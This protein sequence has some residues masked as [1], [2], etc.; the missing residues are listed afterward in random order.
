MEPQQAAIEG[1]RSGLLWI[2]AWVYNVKY[3]NVADE[4]VFKL[5]SHDESSVRPIGYI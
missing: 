1:L 4:C 3:L 2:L 5:P